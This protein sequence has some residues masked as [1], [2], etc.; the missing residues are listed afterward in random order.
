MAVDAVVVV[1]VVVV[2]VAIILVVTTTTTTTPL[3]C[4]ELQCHT[5]SDG[6]FFRG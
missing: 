6:H 3:H 4:P 2:V 1:V 5:S